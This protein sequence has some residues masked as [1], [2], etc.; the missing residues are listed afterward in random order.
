LAIGPLR[1]PA[2]IPASVVELLCALA[3]IWGG[4]AC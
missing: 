3:L 4:A 2:I 1:E